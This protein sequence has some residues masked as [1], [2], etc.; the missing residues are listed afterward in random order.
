[1][2]IVIIN[3]DD[4]GFCDQ[5][6]DGVI[7]AINRGLINSV[8]AFSN[9]TNGLER[10]KRLAPLQD[11][12]DIG[13][14]ISITSGKPLTDMKY[15]TRTLNGQKFFR[16]FT[17]LERPKDDAGQEAAKA[18]LK[19]EINAQIDLM[20]KAGITVKHLSSH[21]NSLI[22]F[23]EYFEA[24]VEIAR[25]RDIKLRSTSIIP[26]GKNKLYIAQLTARSF[27]N[28]GVKSSVEMFSFMRRIEKWK[29]KYTEPIP[30]MPDAIDG[31][32]YGPLGLDNIKT[33]R[34]FGRE[35]RRKVRKMKNNIDSLPSDAVIE[36]C[37]HLTD[38]DGL[39]TYTFADENHPDYYPGV[40]WKYFDSRKVEFA[41]LVKL[42]QL[43]HFPKLSRW[44]DI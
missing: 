8:A 40:D 28:L 22:F 14:H 17:E 10:L 23:P 32:H 3:A 11:K 15:F 19:A 34:E 4:F 37:I 7:K 12:A 9:G 38:P 18:E 35:L 44:K 21:H 41:S 30:A 16:T 43:G 26:K 5:V 39:S 29:E 27:D 20:E 2:A 1:M 33:K 42:K 24:S 31:S 6:D 36:Y 13:C 25:E